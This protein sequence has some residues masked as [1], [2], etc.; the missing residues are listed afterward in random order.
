MK[1]NLSAEDTKT[2]A[3]PI[4]DNRKR[5]SVIS[6]SISVSVFILYDHSKYTRNIANLSAK[7]TKHSLRFIFFF[8]AEYK[9]NR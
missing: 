5:G 9:L 4:A 1:V 6:N 7:K 2:L 8:I 3:L